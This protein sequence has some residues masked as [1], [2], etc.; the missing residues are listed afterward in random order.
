MAIKRY[1]ANKDNTVTN[2]FKENLITRA[3][4]S[5][6]GVSDILETFVGVN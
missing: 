3:T 4:G 2:A 6:M 1:F 5:N